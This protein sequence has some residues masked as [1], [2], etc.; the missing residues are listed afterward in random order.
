MNLRRVFAIYRKDLWD[1]V[2]DARILVTLLTP[3]LIGIFYSFAFNDSDMPSATLVASNPGNSQLVEQ[4]ASMVSGQVDLSIDLVNSPEAVQQQIAD[5]DAD[6][7][8][9]IPEEFDADVAAGESP[10]L[11]VL[12]PQNSSIGGQ[13]VLATLDPLLRQMAGQELPAQVSVDSVALDP[14]NLT[15]IDKMSMRTWSIV[16]SLVLMVSMVALLAVPIVLAEETEKKTID[17]LVLI[18]SY[19]EVV[20]AKALLGVTYVGIM[21][22]I[23]LGITRLQPVDRG[24]FLI[25]LVVLSACLLGF[26]LL[27]GSVFKSATQL[28]TWSGLLLIPAVIPASLIGLGLPSW[29]DRIAGL[30][31]TGAG[32]KLLT[33]AFADTEIYASPWQSFAILIAWAVLFF[34]LLLWQLSRRR[35]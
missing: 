33:N 3:L 10:D 8:L 25:S 2:R 35:A 5:D 27:I 11:R 30:I 26:G 14:A 20:L 16:L 15:V 18:S 31:P 19:G 1:A 12:L 17:A 32:M 23:L 7:G 28:N 4:I 9:V 21:T 6:I 22:A 29:V 34:G 13:Y 24:L